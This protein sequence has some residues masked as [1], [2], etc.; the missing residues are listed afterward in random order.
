MTFV[1]FH[2]GVAALQR[3][4]GAFV[5]IECGRHPALR[6]VATF[7][8]SFSVVLPE[9]AAVRVDMARVAI[10]RRT[11]ELNFLRGDWNFVASAAFDGTVRAE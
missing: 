5:M 7:T 2:V 9:L 4:L 6:V 3:Q 10:V 8:E 11:L 1:T